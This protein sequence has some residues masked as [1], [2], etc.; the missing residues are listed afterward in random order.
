MIQLLEGDCLLVM[1]TLEANSVDT[2]ITDPP[3]GL[4]F[5]GKNWDRGVP[6][7]S[8]WCEAL[9]VAK[10]GALLLAFGGTRTWHR[11]ACAIEDAGWEIR[12]TIM[13]VYG[14]GFPKSHDISKA[15][16]KQSG[17]KPI[18][19]VPAYGSIASR[20]LI[21]QRGWHNINNALIMPPTQTELGKLWDGWGTSLKPSWEPIIVAQK[22]PDGTYAQNALKWG[23]A[24]MWID[25][26]RVGN[27][28]HIVHGKEAGRF[29]PTGGETIKDYH[30]VSGR[31]PANFIHDGSDE[32]LAG[33]PESS[34]CQPHVINSAN[35]KY[36]G[37][38]S[39]TKK[40]G[41]VIGY[42]GNGSAA[43]F[44]YCAKASKAERDAGLDSTRT[45]KYNVPPGGTLCKDVVMELVQSLQKVMSES[46]SKWLIGESGE[47]IMGLCPSGSLSTTL[48]AINRITTSEILRLLTPS[49][50]NACTLV[51]N[52]E[53]ANGGSHAENAESSSGYQPTITS[54]SQE[55]VRGANRVVSQ[56]LSTISAAKNWKELTNIHST[57]KPLA[58]MRYLCRLTKTPT[59]G[60]VLDPFMGSGSTGCAAV[61]EGRDFIGIE[62]DAQWVDVAKRRIEYWRSEAEPLLF[63]EQLCLVPTTLLVED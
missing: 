52:S 35:A 40:H 9:R 26:A 57:V 33:F 15:I 20:E 39:I 45:V 24:G 55:S 60:I 28:S 51:A 3:Y 58:L 48:M 46:E 29:Q 63:A 50:I 61:L 18:E 25:G 19:K 41:E 49:A 56:M 14:S 10:P 31:W 53:M 36:D 1:P 38:G 54:A 43:R 44:F 47:S 62:Q 21:E 34:G 23:V 4:E 12:D 7:E 2:I 16:E 37:W 27:D 42:K 17:V 22:P 6:G 11:L 5:M 13:W 30:E 59:G 32:A 8:F